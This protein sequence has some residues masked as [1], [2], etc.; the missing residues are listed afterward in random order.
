[1][2]HVLAPV[3]GRSKAVSDVPDEVFARGLF[4][5]GLAIDPRPEPQTAVTPIAGTM[6]RL[7]PHAFLVRSAEGPGV[8]VHLGIDTVQ[9]QGKG[10]T[11]H[12]QQDDAVDA[13]QEV[14]TWDPAY[15]ASTGR[16]PVCAVVVLDCQAA[17]TVLPAGGDARAGE[18]LFTVEC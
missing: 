18:P 8:L 11:L 17:T 13:G 10:F 5:P 12:V 3:S 9:M 16:S 15:V 4:G 7:L 14:V 1:M 2:M 6:V